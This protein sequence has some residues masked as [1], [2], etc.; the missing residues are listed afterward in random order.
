MTSDR[1]EELNG[2]LPDIGVF[3]AHANHDTLVTGPTDDRSETEMISEDQR[4]GE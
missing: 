4:N 3:L 1:N 2:K